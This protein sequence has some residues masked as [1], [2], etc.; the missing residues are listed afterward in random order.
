[1]ILKDFILADYLQDI[2]ICDNL[3]NYHKNSNR[4]VPGRVGAGEIQADIKQSTDVALDLGAE[5]NTYTSLLQ[6]VLEK[7]MS[8]FSYSNYYCPFKIIETINIQHYKPN[9]GFKAWHTERITDELPRSARHL[10][11]MTY[12]NDVSTGGETEW[13]YQ[14][15]KVKPKKGLTV[16]WPADWT[17]THR[18]IPAPKENK[19]IITGWFNYV[20]K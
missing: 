8:I 14:N 4:K 3:I 19:Y 7:Y 20:A 16:I 15:L 11:F 17:H 18:G 2:S 9:E 12:L 10:V 6:E 5:R 13:F 1:M